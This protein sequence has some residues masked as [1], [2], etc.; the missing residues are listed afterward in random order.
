MLVL[1]TRKFV[2]VID[3]R[4]DD[5][6]HGH[7][8]KSADFKKALNRLKNTIPKFSPTPDIIIGGDFNLPYMSWPGGGCKPGEFNEERLMINAL[9]E[10]CNEIFLHQIVHVPTHKDGNTLDLVFTNN[11]DLI[12]HAKSISSWILRTVASR[13]ATTML[14]PWKSMVL[15]ILEYC[16]V[17][18]N[19]MSVG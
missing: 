7:P 10:L 19:P 12:Q 13:D 14:I 18:W 1:S 16:S 6:A 5:S 4:P 17:L 9:N 2:I 11:L 8:S 3:R 15:P